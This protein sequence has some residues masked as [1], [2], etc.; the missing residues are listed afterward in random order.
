MPGFDGTGPRAGGPL[1]GRGRGFCVVRIPDG[2]TDGPAGGENAGKPEGKPKQKMEETKMPRGDRTG[3]QGMG[4]MTGRGAGYCAG[5]GAPGYMNRGPGMGSGGGG[6]R[7]GH[8]GGRGHRNWFHA[9]G[10]P[11]WQRAGMGMAAYG[12]P[13]Q[14]QAATGEAELEALKGQA[15][16]LESSLDGIRKRIEELEAKAG[17]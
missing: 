8:G 6:G 7:R 12:F 10:M 16:Y 1:T 3:P 5:F 4:P 2:G 13:A 9:T 14:A 15:E 11:G 17:K